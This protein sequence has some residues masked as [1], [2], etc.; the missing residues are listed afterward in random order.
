MQEEQQTAVKK[1]SR[2]KRGRKPQKKKE[3]GPRKPLVGHN[4]NKR[5]CQ[6]F[7]KFVKRTEVIPQ[8]TWELEPRDW[9][10]ICRTGDLRLW[11]MRLFKTTQL[12]SEEDELVMKSIA[13]IAT[14]L[15]RMEQ[16]AKNGAVDEIHFDKAIK[17]VTWLHKR[18]R[19]KIPYKLMKMSLKRWMT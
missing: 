5:R 4:P 8:L 7:H 3:E 15:M 10:R 2:K 9:K 18:V 16:S 19:K 14:I 12:V 6:D 13:E 17:K 11:M 1:P